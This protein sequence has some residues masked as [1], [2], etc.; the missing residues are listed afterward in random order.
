M[1]VHQNWRVTRLIQFDETKEV[2]KQLNVCPSEL[3]GG[4]PHTV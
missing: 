3:V 1:F 4:T 2:I